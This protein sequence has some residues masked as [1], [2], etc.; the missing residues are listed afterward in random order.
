LDTKDTMNVEQ[1]AA[2]VKLLLLDCD[3]VLTDGRITLVEGGDEQIKSAVAALDAAIRSGHKTEI[4]AMIVPGELSNF[5][6]GIIGTQPDV[7]Q[8]KVLRTDQL[9]PERFAADVTLTARTL[10]QERSGPAVYIFARTPAGWKL[11]EI[12]IFEVR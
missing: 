12:P 11:S 8:T 6:K 4:D 5:S 7:W 10:G 3:G 9:S 2:R 1:R